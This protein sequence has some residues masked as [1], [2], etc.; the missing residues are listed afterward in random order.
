MPIFQHTERTFW[1]SGGTKSW[2]LTTNLT[3]YGRRQVN[4]D[5]A[6]FL[7]SASHVESSIVGVSKNA[8]R[9]VL[10]HSA[11]NCKDNTTFW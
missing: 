5:K 3:N 9:W 2:N 6:K 11:M 8:T 1:S 7:I 4:P 10:S